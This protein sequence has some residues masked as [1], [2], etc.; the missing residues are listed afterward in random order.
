MSSHVVSVRNLKGQA[1]RG[2]WRSGVASLLLRFYT[3]GL[4]LRRAVKYY[5][6]EFPW[7]RALEPWAGTGGALPFFPLIQI[8]VAIFSYGCALGR[9][10]TKYFFCFETDS[11]PNC[12]AQSACFVRTSQRSTC[13]CNATFDGPIAAIMSTNYGFVHLVREVFH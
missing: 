11:W 9:S 6:S 2:M 8:E 5:C 3:D 7:R 4:G 13:V 1:H 12:L 10:G